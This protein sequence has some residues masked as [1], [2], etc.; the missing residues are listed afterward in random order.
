M[1]SRIIEGYNYYDNVDFDNP[2]PGFK[3]M[4][5]FVIKG[6]II[7]S[8]ESRENLISYFKKKNKTAFLSIVVSHYNYSFD[9]TLKDISGTCKLNTLVRYQDL[10]LL[11]SGASDSMSRITYLHLQWYEKLLLKMLHKNTIVQKKEFWMWLINI[12]VAF[13][14]IIFSYLSYKNGFLK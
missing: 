8:S 7:Y 3:S 14:A 13:L 4:G 10:A 12:F 6:K 1:K 9:D 11:N 5:Y 2:G